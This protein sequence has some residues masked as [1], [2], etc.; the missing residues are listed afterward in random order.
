MFG[1]PNTE[2]SETEGFPAF[3]WQLDGV[4]IV[5]YVFDRFGP[6]EHMR[7]IKA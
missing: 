5:H 4:T 2:R 3:S 7:I 6:E 1:E